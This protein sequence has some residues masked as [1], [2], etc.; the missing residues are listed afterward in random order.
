MKITKYH[1][2]MVAACVG[3]ATIPC[4]QAEDAGLTSP[5]LDHAEVRIPYVELRKLWAA[6]QAEKPAAPQKEIV[7]V[8]KILAA[9]YR[10]NLA[11]GKTQLEA[12]F[13][14]ESFGGKW[15]RLPLMGA[16]LAVASVEPPDAR[17]VVEED[18]LCLLVKEGGTQ[19]VKVRFVDNKLS[20][21]SGATLLQLTTAP[22][23]VGSLEV[24]GVPVTRTLKL[25]DNVAPALESGAVLIALPAKGGDMV[26]SLTDAVQEPKPEPAPLPPQPS[27]WS[28]QNE[29]LVFEGEGELNYRVR[30]H[31]MALNGSALEAVL[32]LPSNARSIKVTGDDIEDAKYARSAE[33]KLELRARWKTRDVQ[34]R[35]LRISYALQQLPLAHEWE[36]RA[37]TQLKED[38]VKTVFMIAVPQGKEFSGA[39]LQGPMSSAKLPKWVGSETTL[40]EFDTVT[41]TAS[42]SLQSKL[43]PRMETA[44]AIVTRSDYSS[45]VV[46]DGSVLTEATLEIEHVEGLRWSFTLPEKGILLQC[47]VGGVPVKPVARAGG[48]IEIILAEP[49]GGKTAKTTVS[50]SYT[51]AKNKLDAVEGQIALELPLTPLF[52]SEVTWNIELPDSYELTAVGGNTDVASESTRGKENITNRLKKLCRNERPAAELFYRKRGLN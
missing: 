48:G 4:A 30:V 25:G 13:R 50:F 16:G 22:C 46:G 49:G 14:A 43:L 2:L 45:K 26:L 32:V 20:V 18:E 23:A 3:M 24:R 28:L 38:R 10:L 41:A 34:E 42:A 7:P 39:N 9:H 33:G 31:A 17:L 29:A 5:A 12:E 6:A 11:G 27:D 37:P 40:K 8:G 21:A 51:T 36:L 35:E 44:P 47:S 15:E 19:N 1:S 52:I